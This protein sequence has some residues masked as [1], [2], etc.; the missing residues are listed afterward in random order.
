MIEEKIGRFKELFFDAY[1]LIFKKQENVPI[2][3]IADI[4]QAVSQRFYEVQ[5]LVLTEEQFDVLLRKIPFATDEYIIS[6]GR[7][8][9]A[10]EKVFEYEKN[11]Y[12]TL[13]IRFLNKEEKS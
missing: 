1:N 4:R 6:L 13:S 3:D 12:R 7:A 8:M 5:K 11:Y 10:E 2:V 9:G